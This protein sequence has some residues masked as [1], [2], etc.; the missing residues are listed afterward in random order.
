M[1]GSQ[2]YAVRVSGR[3]GSGCRRWTLGSTTSATAIQG[4]NVNL[5]TGALYGPRTAFAIETNGQLENARAYE[6]VVVA[7]RNGAAVRVKDV[8]RALDSVENDKTA[9]WRGDRAACRARWCWAFKS[10]RA[11]TR[12]RSSQR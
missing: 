3:S 10:S 5:P 6:D 8:G 9:A 7:Y 1:F 12:S 11:P 4:A 2:K